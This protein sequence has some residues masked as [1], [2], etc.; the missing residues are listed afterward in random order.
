MIECET[1]NYL[2]AGGLAVSGYIYML[3]RMKLVK[4]HD[5]ESDLIKKAYFDPL[6]SLPNA[7]NI[8]I[9]LDDQIYRC[10][11]R[12]KSFFTAVITVDNLNDEAIAESG[13]RLFNSIRK[14]DTV[15]YL[16]NGI[17]V[18]LFNEYLEESNAD[19]I[20]NRINKAFEK[21]FTV[22]NHTTK[23]SIEINTNK[24]P[25]KATVAEL[26]SQAK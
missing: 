15:G 17:F 24:Y 23:V 22:N 6:T 16:S 20:F 26:L 19:I 3:Q 13:L 1:L 9:I 14:E 8:N 11:R 10:Q 25:E 21:M 18:I 7:E 5:V 4:Q 12:N 2:L